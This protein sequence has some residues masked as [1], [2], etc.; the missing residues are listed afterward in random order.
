M[1]WTAD[2]QSLFVGKQPSPRTWS[3]ARL[4]VADGRREPVVSFGPSD[5]AGVVT[6]ALPRISAD[7]KVYAYRYSQY[8]SDLFVGDGI[9]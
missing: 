3:I 7:G 8:L 9:R 1:R 4:R 5:P 2:G 6:V